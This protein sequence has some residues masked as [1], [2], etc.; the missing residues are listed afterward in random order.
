MLQDFAACKPG[1]WFDT[2]DNPPLWSLSYEWWFYMMF[3]PVYSRI[4]VRW[5]LP[6]VAILSLGGLLTYAWH[7]NQISLFLLYFIIWWAGLE[8]SRTYCR[9]TTP[10]FYTQRS[11]ALILAGFVTIIPVVVLYLMPRPEHLSFGLHPILEIRHFAAAL[12]L[13]SIG[14]TWSH[15]RWRRFYAVFGAFSAFAPISYAVYVFH[16]PLV[17]STMSE[18]WLPNPAVHVAVFVSLTIGL[19]YLAERTMRRLI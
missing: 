6:L 2:F 9:G 16:F 3:F 15:F 19:A 11:S 12:V 10:T 4:P 8:I 1:V 13:L 5:Q 18:G 14:L 17:I 7:P